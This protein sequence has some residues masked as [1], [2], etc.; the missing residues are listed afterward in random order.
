[1][2]PTGLASAFVLQPL[3]LRRSAGCKAISRRLTTKAAASCGS[4][5]VNSMS[6]F[7]DAFSSEPGTIFPVVAV[8]KEGYTSWLEVQSKQTKAWLKMVKFDPKNTGAFAILPKFSFDEVK[9]I[10][11]AIISTGTEPDAPWT[12]ADLPN[13]LPGGHT[14]ELRGDFN[15]DA[16]ALGWALGSY[17]FLKYKTNKPNRD[18][19]KAALKASPSSLVSSAISAT[20]LVRDLI[21]HHAD[22]MCPEQLE[23]AMKALA[24]KYEA[25]CESIVGDELLVKNF[26]LVHAVGRAALQD[27]CKPRLIDLRWGPSD[28]PL[29][30]LVGKGVCY[31][32]GGL[33]LKPGAAM[34]NMKKDMGGAATVLGLASMIMQ[35]ELDVSLRVIVPAVENSI[36]GNSFRPGDVVPSRKGINTEIDNTDAEGR[37][38]LADALA[39]AC[40]EKPKLVVDC[41]TLTGAQRIA[42]GTDIPSSFC[43]NSA[44]GR[45]LF[46][47]SRE[48]EDLIWELPLHKPYRRMLDSSIADIKNSSAGG[49][50]GA[51]TAAL[52]LK[53]FVSSETEWIHIDHMGY[54]P[55]SRPGR[56][57]GGEA[58]GMRALYR[59]IQ[60]DFC[61]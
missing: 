19:Q 57:E 56:P 48:Q 30:V 51:I 38:I 45:K 3:L 58:Q 10:D 36:S 26:P 34:R 29:I 13:K 24:E 52:Y 60:S 40:E 37:L 49:Y 12:Y 39:L 18:G 31:D 15:D 50:A 1:M 4:E 7:S 61:T 28:K 9:A 17:S 25:R 27:K 5:C 8:T 44:T 46:E 6:R 54:N 16:A 53:E 23:A 41:A 21:N 14:Y 33:N 11:G 2:S 32:T 22:D 43:T 59:L 55:S 20:Y 47:Y 35:N 42:L